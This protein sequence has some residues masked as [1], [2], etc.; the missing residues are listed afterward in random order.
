[1]GG[2]PGGGAAWPDP[3]GM[4]G[5]ELLFDLAVVALVAAAAGLAC[6]AL[7]QSVIVGYLAAGIAIGPHTPPFQL[8]ADAARIQVLADLGLLF[9]VFGIGLGFSLPRLKRLGASLVVAA[10]AG[11]LLVLLAGRTGA[12][13]LGFS[14]AQAL[15]IAGVLMVSSSAIIAKVLEEIRA[16]HTRWGQMALGTTLLEDVVAITM[17]TI[18]GSLAAIEAGGGGDAPV[19]QVVGSFVGFLAVLFVATLLL[20]PRLLRWLD[21]R[22]SVELRMLAVAGGL[23]ALAVLAVN[24]GYSMALAAFLLGAVIGSTPQQ[25]EVDRLFEGLRH[26]FGAVFFVAMGMMLDLQLL[27]ASWLALVALAAGALVVRGAALCVGLLVAGNEARDSIRAALALTP[28]G[29]FS[30]V[31]AFLGVQSGIMGEGF[32]A[33]AV[34]ASLATCVVAPALVRRAD[35]ASDAVLRRTPRW[36]LRGLDAYR[37][38]IERLQASLGSN[39]A[40]KLIAPRLGQALLQLLVAGGILA[41]SIPGSELAARALGPDLLVQGGTAML[42]LAGAGLAAL[43]LLVA[44]WRNTGATSMILAEALTMRRGPKAA[45]VA[46]RIE[47]GA[48]AAAIALGAVW[49]ALV[50]PKDQVALPF[51]VALLVLLASAAILLRKRLVYWNSFFEVEF[52]KELRDAATGPVARASRFPQIARR[53]EWRVRTEEI[54]LPPDTQHAG[55]RIDELALRPDYGVSIAGIDRGGYALTRPSRST[56]VFPG[57]KLL[58]LGAPEALERA[59]AFLRQRDDHPKWA[60]D[61]QALATEPAQVPDG[62]AWDGRGLA[63]LDLV[64]RF[65]VQVAAIRRGG[66]EMA[67]PGPGDVLRAGDMLLLVGSHE[68]IRALAAALAGPAPEDAKEPARAADS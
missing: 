41:L 35:A 30:F 21:R 56:Q 5:M 51:L 38:T 27:A 65:G 32:Y 28:L 68:A 29:E 26:L 13:A 14:E 7:K 53:R 60:G 47:R 67:R 42:V 34:G 20:A 57:D 23:L 6:R 50:L 4:A 1:M 11:A 63:D 8:V 45:P 59:E 54:E 9:L 33:A 37:G 22:A 61:F 43:P 49:I 2:L 46:T 64:G 18:L 44:F 58:L 40:W 36:L 16:T 66:K 10:A 19:A 39:L 3:A 31:I 62:S 17:L 24:L 12:M 52:K 55:K 15:F 48:A 25:S